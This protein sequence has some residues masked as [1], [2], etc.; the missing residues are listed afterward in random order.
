MISN[1]L[2]VRICG[3]SADLHDYQWDSNRPENSCARARPANQ[4]PVGVV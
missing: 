2:L 1:L 4:Q 3:G